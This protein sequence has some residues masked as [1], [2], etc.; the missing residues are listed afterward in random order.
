MVAIK[1]GVEEVFKGASCYFVQPGEAYRAVLMTK[2]RVSLFCS[3]QIVGA[4][5]PAADVSETWKCRSILPSWCQYWNLEE[6]QPKAVQNLCPAVCIKSA[7]GAREVIMA[8]T[9]PHAASVDPEEELSEVSLDEPSAVRVDDAGDNFRID[10]AVEGKSEFQSTVQLSNANDGRAMEGGTLI[11]QS[12]GPSSGGSGTQAT[13]NPSGSNGNQESVPESASRRP[14]LSISPGISV[15]PAVAALPPISPAAQALKQRQ[16][17][18]D[19]SNAP[20]PAV[21][22]TT[23][24]PSGAHTDPL[25]P[26]FLPVNQFQQFQQSEELSVLI[27]FPTQVDVGLPCFGLLAFT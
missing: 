26:Y 21:T 22:P 13:G 10:P 19:A 20:S 8:E 27:C 5:T 1:L 15:S 7:L 24:P 3:G 11:S 23:T 25:L 12:N 14:S 6:D 18:V 9:Q 16:E 17:A 4:G 2:K